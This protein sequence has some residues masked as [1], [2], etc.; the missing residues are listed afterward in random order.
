MHAQTRH[1]HGTLSIDIPASWREESVTIYSNGSAGDDAV[2]VVVRR[3]IVDPRTTSSMYADIQLVELAKALPAFALINRS[4]IQVANMRGIRLHYSWV[5]Q[6][7]QYKQTQTIFRDSAKSA[8]CV[9]MTSSPKAVRN[10]NDDFAM[11]VGSIR[12]FEPSTVE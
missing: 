8:I 7:V 3:E 2:S 5:V 10:W 11:I 6:G 12:V 1:L 4:D 9:I